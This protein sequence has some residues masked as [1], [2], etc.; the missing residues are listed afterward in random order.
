MDQLL[1][2]LREGDTLVVWKLDRLARS[3]IDFT[4]K[5]TLFNEQG[6]LFKSITEPFIDTTNS[7][8]HAD[9]FTNM[10]AA[11][12]QFERDLIKER[13]KAGG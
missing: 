1:S 2:K 13:T 4:Q 6:I 7:S 9:L 8:P 3:L 5:M 12:A 11:M 10:I